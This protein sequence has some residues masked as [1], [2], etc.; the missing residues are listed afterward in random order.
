MMW[1]AR[2]PVRFMGLRTTFTSPQNSSPRPYVV[3]PLFGWRKVRGSDLFLLSLLKLLR[4]VDNY[5][6]DRPSRRFELQTELFFN[7]GENRRHSW[8]C[9]CG[10]F[11][12]CRHRVILKRRALS[13]LQPVRQPDVVIPG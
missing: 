7:S 8:I 11:R 4:A 5:H 3:M 2:S 10:S 13:G 12:S 1:E 6:G 9:G